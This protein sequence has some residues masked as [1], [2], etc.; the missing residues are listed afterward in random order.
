MVKNTFKIS[1]LISASIF[2]SVFASADDSSIFLKLAQGQE[3]EKLGKYQEAL[4]EYES[5]MREDP[6][7]KHV[8]M[9]LGYIYQYELNDKK[10]AIEFYK[11]GIDYAPNDYGM[12]FNLMYAYFD[13]GDFDSAM[14][15]YERLSSMQHKH[16]HTFPRDTL[17]KIFLNM[18]EDEVISFCKK[19]LA[20]NP[21]DSILR[22]KL[23]KLYR[24]Y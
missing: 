19:F 5:A 8:Y 24:V 17:S 7:N 12:S 10:K 6:I 23:S 21:S 9:S 2:I 16:S 11:K 3:Y 1:L 22:E 4:A 20:I 13:I 15:L 18:N 14:R